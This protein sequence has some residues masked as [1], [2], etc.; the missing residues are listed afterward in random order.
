MKNV[1]DLT[2]I[3]QEIEDQECRLKE[4]R[5]ALHTIEHCGKVAIN[6]TMYNTAS[7]K[8]NKIDLTGLELL[9]LRQHISRSLKDYAINLLLQNGIEYKP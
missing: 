2:E 5:R 8:E 1:K 9:Q 6:V 4:I 3:D 7:N